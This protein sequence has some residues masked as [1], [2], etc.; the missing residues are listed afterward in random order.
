HP[1]HERDALRQVPVF[2]VVLDSG[3]QVVDSAAG[4]GD[5]LAFDLQDQ[6][7]HAVSGRML[8]P[9]VDDD[10]LAG[11]ALLAGGLDDLVPVLPA[12]SYQGFAHQ[13]YDLRWSGGGIFAPLYSTGTPPSG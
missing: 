13:L 2:E 4:L 11:L 10:P 1:G 6:S 3:V 5:G 9:H 7:Q 12:E 8:R